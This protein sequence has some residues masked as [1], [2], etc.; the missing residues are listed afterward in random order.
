MAMNTRNQRR[1]LPD[2]YSQLVHLRD[3]VADFLQPFAMLMPKLHRANEELRAGYRACQ[4]QSPFDSNCF[5][6][7]HAALEQNLLSVRTLPAPL[8][9]YLDDEYFDSFEQLVRLGPTLCAV[10]VHRDSS[11][12]I[13]ETLRSQINLDSRITKAIGRAVTSVDD[14][15]RQIMAKLDETVRALSKAEEIDF[16]F[17]RSGDGYDIRGFGKRGHVS[18]LKGLGQIAML[19]R[20][21]N[22]SVPMIDLISL[23]EGEHQRAD[24][25]SLQPVLDD[26]AKKN[27]AKEVSE[28]K[29]DLER[30]KR[31]N[32]LAAVDRLTGEINT[33]E[34]HYA[35]STGLGGRSRE[36]KDKTGT[37]R[38]S[39]HGALKRAYKALRGAK[40]P[41]SKVADHFENSISSESGTF[42]YRPVDA[43]PAWSDVRPEVAICTTL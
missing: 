38:A 14:L 42:I 4:A 40:P 6:V 33:L 23:V 37:H 19:I 34:Q 31:D 9:D 30:A 11:A 15:Y 3:V 2:D 5:D 13:A 1:L 17:A 12:D 43:Q 20:R 24:S 21:S 26:K 41:L 32:D 8:L 29:V 25:S 16:V 36:L 7:L 18:Y 28:L 22:E 27:I 10:G 39:I 35:A